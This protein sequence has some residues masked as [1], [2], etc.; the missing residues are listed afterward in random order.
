MAAPIHSAFGEHELRGQLSRLSSI[1]EDPEVEAV[2][3]KLVQDE[4]RGGDPKL[5]ANLSARQLSSGTLKRISQRT[6]TDIQDAKA[7]IQILPDLE[8]IMQILISSILAPKDMVTARLSYSVDKTR[9][10]SE[11]MGKML[12]VVQTFFDD[13]YKI[14]DLLPKMLEDILFLKGSYPVLILPENAIDEIINNPRRVSFEHLLESAQ[15]KQWNSDHIGLL[16]PGPTA[17]TAGRSQ[18]GLESE[19]FGTQMGSMLNYKADLFVTTP[20]T[21]KG[22]ADLKL[23]VIDN[24]DILK[25]QRL[26]ERIRKERVATVLGKRQLGNRLKT[27]QPVAVER[28]PPTGR[29][30][31]ENLN[32]STIITGVRSQP[33]SF[34]SFSDH[35]VYRSRSRHRSLSHTVAIPTPDR[36]DRPSVGHPLVTRWPS[37][38]VIPVHVPGEPKNHVGYFL[39]L[40]EWGNPVSLETNRDYYSDMGMML[41]QNTTLTS[42]LINTTNRATNGRQDP[43]T[44]EE[45]RELEQAYVDVV[46]N[47]LR[48]RLKS[49]VYGSNV[50]IARP[51][52]VY[53][54]MLARTYSQQLTQL[55]WVPAEMMTYMAFDYDEYGIGQSLLAKSKII[56]GLRAVLLFAN[57]TAGVK[58]SINRTRLKITLDPDD[59]DP[60]QAVEE[61]IHNYVRSSR[62]MLPIGINEPNDIL[63]YLSNASVEVEVAP[64]GNQRYPETSMMVENTKSDIGKPDTELEESLKDRHTMS[65]G[66]SPEM[67]N[68]ARGADFATSVVQNNLLLIKRVMTYQGEF[69]P[70]L[71][72]FM[73]RFTISS[74]PLMEELRA[75]VRAN[76]EHLSKAQ[77]NDQRAAVAA[78]GVEVDEDLAGLVQIIKDKA[79]DDNVAVDA[80]VY[81]FIQAIR[82]ALPSPDTGV[83]KN[84]LEALEQYEKMLDIGLKYYFDPESMTKELLGKL[85][86]EVFKAIGLALKAR[87][88]RLYMRSNGVLP[89]LADLTAFSEEDGAAL[90]LLKEEQAH[91][92]GLRKSV[93]GFSKYVI[94]QVG[95]VDKQYDE[96]LKANG[97]EA[98]SGG[99]Y[100]GGFSSDTSGGGGG[101]DFGG[102][103]GGD[104][105][106]TGD[107]STNADSELTASDGTDP[108]EGDAD[109]PDATKAEGDNAQPDQNSPPV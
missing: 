55:L 15:Y 27:G 35:G 63:S 102:G 22:P 74:E 64:N 51:T 37:E 56:G 108:G 73:Q 72:E 3:S 79:A 39:L 12:T 26:Q 87:F 2:L 67:V 66:L 21:G 75:I 94:E 57:V 61:Y 32:A 9:F 5:R 30:S 52:E 81:E 31:N 70:Y 54:M 38:A 48:Q 89:E 80:V 104:D 33:S 77:V 101:F 100:S 49:G 85:S 90:D 82:L 98:P 41:K 65:L 19:G 13:T 8:L 29:V 96:S 42:Q 92:D 68:N 91:L 16:G 59:P 24:P 106:G 76:I 47:D 109:E 40:D 62:G 50:K 60:E 10:T 7:L 36:L 103:G 25:R 83:L 97:V 17:E 46:E 18:A 44:Q 95:I 53:R 84:Q 20:T 86:P 11:V 71:E 45:I 88:M 28:L 34:T 23:R 107:T 1:R 99:G 69:L 6:I 58:N 93:L 78:G 105:F 4:R 14:N 43:N